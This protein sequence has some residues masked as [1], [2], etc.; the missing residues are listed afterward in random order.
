MQGG[1]E[2]RAAPQGAELQFSASQFSPPRCSAVRLPARWRGH[3]RPQG[4]C[5]PCPISNQLPSQGAGRQP[6]HH[7]GS[8]QSSHASKNHLSL[9]PMGSRSC[10]WLRYSHWWHQLLLLEPIIHLQSW[11]FCFFPS[12]AWGCRSC[13][14]EH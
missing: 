2:S 10:R 7:A 11:Y 9:T 14:R 1:E 8:Q 5:I 4:G 3:W 12:R 13:W 6:L